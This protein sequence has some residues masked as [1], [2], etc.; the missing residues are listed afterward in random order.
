MKQS[1]INKDKKKTKTTLSRKSLN[2][3]SYLTKVLQIDFH[4]VT[5]KS[6]EHTYIHS[7]IRSVTL[8]KKSVQLFTF[9]RFPHYSNI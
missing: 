9:I 8:K 2:L 7:K 5:I 6:I 1:K 4:E 3:V